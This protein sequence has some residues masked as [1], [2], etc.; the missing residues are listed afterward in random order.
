MHEVNR[1]TANALSPN[2][3]KSLLHEISRIP[4]FIDRCFEYELLLVSIQRV[5]LVQNPSLMVDTIFE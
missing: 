3:K 1:E 5:F 4:A 2:Q